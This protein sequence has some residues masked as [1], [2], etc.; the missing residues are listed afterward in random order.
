MTQILYATTNPGKLKEAKS[1]FAAHNL[2]LLGPDD[3]GLNIDVDE[4]GATLEENARL[5]ADAYQRI[6]S[7]TTL[8]IGDDTGIEIDALGGEP[9]IKVRRWKGYKMSDEEII[10]Y[11][12]ERLKDQ[13]NRNAQF[14]TV[15]ALAS[16]IEVKYF[17]GI[18]RGEI[19][20]KPKAER[21]VGMPFWPIFFI[22]K[23]TMTLGQFH[24]SPIT[25]QLKNPTHREIAIIKVVEYISA[26]FDLSNH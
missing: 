7:S 20:E 21:E 14:R 9:G 24:A 16:P 13:P 2:I 10:S 3:L 4:V 11:T 17:D 12:L 26:N 1:I 22:P 6:A 15:L 23:L 5:K 19:L 8:V 25:F 18:L